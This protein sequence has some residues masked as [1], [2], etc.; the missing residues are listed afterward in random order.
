MATLLV[1]PASGPLRGSVPVPSDK[2]ISHRAV[3]FAALSNGR[4]E[5]RQ[6]SYGSDNVA[7][8]DA[9]RAMGV[10]VEDDEN[11]TLHITGVGLRGLKPPTDVIDCGNSGTG[12]RLL[13]GV[14]AAQPFES[15]LVGDA[16]LSRRPMG[17]ITGP[18]TQRGAVIVGTPHGTKEGE[19]TAPLK[20]GPLPEG[21]LLEAFE[22]ASPIASAQVKTALLLSG[23]YA[24]GPTLLSEPVISRDHTERM[25]AALRLPISSVGPALALHPPA[26]PNCIEPFEI[27]LP[28]DLSAA[29]FILAAGLIVPDSC[30]VSRSTGVNPTRA[31]FVNIVRSL[32]GNL[33]ITSQGDSL[34]EE[35]GEL[36]AFGGPLRGAEIGGETATRAIDEIPIC[37]AL[38]ARAN[39]ATE[40]HDVAELRVKESDRIGA[41]IKVLREFGIEAEELETGLRVHGQPSGA[42]KSAKVTS[43]GDHRIAMTAAVLGLVADGETVVEDADCIGTSF[44]R[45]AGTLRALGADVEVKP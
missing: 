16:S 14:L 4:C 39:G 43:H 10:K 12:M 37:C 3:I 17:R 1:R 36:T 41:M 21:K 19:V 24:S 32:G 38:A 11:G 28:G 29:A 9:F 26:D 27:D 18:L 45:F 6:F 31:G 20:I 5:L 40:F 35:L 8:V 30:V 23:L 42:L 13:A 33:E 25:M 2:S 44:P 15:E 22:Y 7:T 34:G